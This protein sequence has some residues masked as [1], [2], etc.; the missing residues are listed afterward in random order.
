[1]GD[2]VF[3]IKMFK[4]ILLNNKFLCEKAQIIL[5]NIE[6]T[7]FTYHSIQSYLINNNSVNNK[8]RLFL[9]RKKHEK[10]MNA[11]KERFKEKVKIIKSNEKML[12]I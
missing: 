6:N 11:L 4:Y 12:L 8:L 5:A 2:F 10:E 3:L 7:M 9:N 1:M